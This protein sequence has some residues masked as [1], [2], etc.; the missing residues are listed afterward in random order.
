MAN[1]NDGLTAGLA[2]V[3]TTNLVDAV[4]WFKRSLRVGILRS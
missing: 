1:L 2:V 3:L 4:Q